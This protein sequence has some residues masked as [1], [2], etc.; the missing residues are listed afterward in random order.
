MK[1]VWPGPAFQC[2]LQNEISPVSGTRVRLLPTVASW[3]APGQL[4]G[5]PQNH[6]ASIADG[7]PDWATVGNGASEA[8]T[9]RPGEKVRARTERGDDSSLAKREWSQG[10]D[11]SRSAA[12]GKAVLAQ[13]QLI[14]EIH[15]EQ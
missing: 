8:K 7:G 4:K 9:L 10:E 13:A 2:L 12:C 15:K 14:Y 3:A 6:S 11:G 5:V 1:S